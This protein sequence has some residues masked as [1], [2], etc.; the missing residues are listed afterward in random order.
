MRMIFAQDFTHHRC[1]FARPGIAS[2]PQ[3]LVHGV[4]QPALD[5]LETVTDVG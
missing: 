2:E 3:V 4:Q 1:G 5:R